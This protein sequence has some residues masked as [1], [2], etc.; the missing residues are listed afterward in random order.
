MNDISKEETNSDDL[1][2]TVSDFKLFLK[3]WHF[4]QRR[5]EK[6]NDRAIRFP[7]LQSVLD[8]YYGLSNP[9]LIKD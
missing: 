6:Q 3:Q 9:K 7:I 1:S 4:E 8:V 2:Q 5:Q